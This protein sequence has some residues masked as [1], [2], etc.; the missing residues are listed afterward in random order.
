MSNTTSIKQ[1]PEKKISR[2]ELDKIDID[3]ESD[4]AA[5]IKYLADKFLKQ[6][7][8]LT[9]K[10]I[11]YIINENNIWAPITFKSLKD[12][13]INMHHTHDFSKQRVEITE[14]IVALSHIDEDSFPGWNIDLKPE[15]VVFKNK[16]VNIF[17]NEVSDIR[18]EQYITT[19]IHRN[20][21]PNATCPTWIK[22]LDQ[23]LEGKEESRLLLQEYF[24]YIICNRM[25][26][27]KCLLLI[28][29]KRCGK[30]KVSETAIELVGKAGCSAVD[31]Q[32]MDRDKQA[33]GSMFGKQLNAPDEIDK[34]SKLGKGFR[35]AISGGLM[36]GKLLWIDDI[37]FTPTCK[38]IF[39]ANEMPVAWGAGEAQEANLDRLLIIKFSKQ[40]FGSAD[41]KLLI[42]KIRNEIEGIIN[43]SIEGLKRLLFNQQFTENT[44]EEI[45]AIK[46]TYEEESRSELYNFIYGSGLFEFDEKYHIPKDKLCLL[47]WES[48]G[49]S[50]K[51][52]PQRLD[53]G[54]IGKEM[55]NNNLKFYSSKTGS[56][57]T[58]KGLRLINDKKEIQ[59]DRSRF[60]KNVQESF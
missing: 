10:N 40:F 32:E 30:S 2:A 20:F 27:R 13:T 29:P 37:S 17:T 3:D 28:G 47:F 56:T 5:V 46:K 31:P 33:R 42:E 19:H 18:P 52:F 16:I 50:E 44:D 6:N 38:H 41:D 8:I 55:N 48:L 45:L 34:H 23:W 1:P 15:E 12:K 58:Y 51:N 36:R 54:K 4:K 21:N 53:K 7:K 59:E 35:S 39:T 11:T 49:Y 26:F 43:W 9:I 22:C 60:V 14:R 24:G 25:H 57:Q